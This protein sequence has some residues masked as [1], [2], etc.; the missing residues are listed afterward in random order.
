MHIS[1]RLEGRYL[2]DGWR[3]IERVPVQEGMTGSNFSIGY[4]AEQSGGRGGFVKV[5]DISKAMSSTEDPARL[6]EELTTAFNFE[7]NLLQECSG[8]S[9]VVSAL[10]EG[11][12]QEGVEVAQYI[13]FELAESDL[14]KL[15]LSLSF[16]NALNFRTLHNVAVG[17]SQLH[18]KGIAHQDIKPSNVLIF[19]RDGSKIADLGR[20][21]VSS[22]VGPHDLW[23]IPGDHAYAP[24]ELIYRQVSDDWN[25]RRRASD[26]YQLG[27]L[28]VFAFSG[29]GLMPVL[30]RNTHRDHRPDAWSG[31]YG[32]VL[33]YL[34]GYFRNALD[35]VSPRFPAE[36]RSDLTAAVA[37]LCCLDPRRRGHPRNH[38]TGNPYG[39]DRFVSFFDR[40]AH[41]QEMRLTKVL[42]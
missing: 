37:Q 25:I 33:G 34:E 42:Q 6:L 41:R 24:P 26:L 31:T 18:G 7:R 4:R 2:K 21:S 15:G 9:R 30:L 23:R 38:A 36:C 29:V 20:S 39:L 12:V 14:R 1:E 28:I 32:E 10:S 40:L 22:K 11:A 5:L 3:V 8:L 16:D 27:S 35:E 13:I 19:E 17:L